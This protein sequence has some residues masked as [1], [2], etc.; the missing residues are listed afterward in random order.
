MTVSKICIYHNSHCSKSRS[1]L[2]L[3]EQHGEPFEII[4][5]LQT[6][7]TPAELEGLLHLLGISAR[8]LLRS[9]EDVYQQLGLDNLLLDEETL[10]AAMTA[11]PCLIERPIVVANG[12]AIIGRPP[13]QVFAVL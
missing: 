11:H 12:K 5:Y 10:I 4:H 1:A 3:L 7:P 13:E 6:P 2:A 8:Q 9:G